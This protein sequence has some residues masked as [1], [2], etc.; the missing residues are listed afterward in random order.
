MRCARSPTQ[1]YSSDLG[2]CVG[3][4][5]R[6]L[7]AACKPGSALIGDSWFGS[8]R[9]AVE[10][11]KWEVE[12]VGVVKTAH[13]LFPKAWL[14]QTLK[15]KSAGSRLVLTTTYQGVKLVALG[16]KYNKRK[17]LCFITTEGAGNTMNGN[18]Y[19]QRW[20]DEHGNLHM[21]EV[22][23]PAVVSEYFEASPR[24]DNQNQSRQHDLA[25]EEKWDTQC[26]WFRLWTTLIGMTVTDMWKLVKFHTNS[27]H[28]FHSSTIKEFADELAYALLNNNMADN[29]PLQRRVRLPLVEISEPDKTNQDLSF[30]QHTLMHLGKKEGTRGQTQARCRHCMVLYG[31]ESWTTQYCLECGIELCIPGKHGPPC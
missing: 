6:L 24:I 21:R 1:E 16:Y 25:L 19:I 31:R 30:A 12:F 11:W 3:C 20:P 27:M 8:A 22:A 9:A 23:R 15:D 17:V 13:S 14:E 29:R 5:M 28:R 26:G 7:E 2:G 18:P 10:A 4:T